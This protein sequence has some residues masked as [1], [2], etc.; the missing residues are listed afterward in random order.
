MSDGR[1]SG[2]SY[3]RGR[4]RGSIGEGSGECQRGGAVES[5]MGGAEVGRAVE[6]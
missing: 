3:G 1:G 5:Q 6:C 4:G 2:E